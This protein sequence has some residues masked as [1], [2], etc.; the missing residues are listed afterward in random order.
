MPFFECGSE[1]GKA[2]AAGGAEEGDGLFVGALHWTIQSFETNGRD[3]DVCEHPSMHPTAASRPSFYTRC[4]GKA[5]R[6]RTLTDERRDET[7]RTWERICVERS[8][9]RYISWCERLLHVRC[10]EMVAAGGEIIGPLLTGCGSPRCSPRSCYISRASCC[11]CCSLLLNIT[12]FND[13]IAKAQI[14][15]DK[16]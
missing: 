14:R 1:T 4:E 16:A 3:R 5:R 15:K 10:G 7:R 11:I 13:C 8:A 12:T 9:Y 2:G 6:A